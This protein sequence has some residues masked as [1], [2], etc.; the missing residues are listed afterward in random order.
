MKTLKIVLCLLLL[1]LTLSACSA[2]KTNDKWNTSEMAGIADPGFVVVSKNKTSN[3][4]K[5]LFKNVEV[6]AANEFLKQLYATEFKENVNYNYT[7]SFYTYAA[8]NSAGKSIDFEYNIAE[9]T[10]SFTYSLSGGTASVSGV[11][12]MGYFIGV[13]FEKDMDLDFKNYSVWLYYSINPEVQKTSQSEKTVSCMLKDI[14]IKSASRLG[15]L[16]IS[17]DVFKEATIN[18]VSC[19]NQ[20]FIDPNFIVRQRGI[21]KFSTD[22]PNSQNQKTYFDAMSV[23]QADLNFVVTFTAEVVTDKGTYTKAY[24]IPVL[25]AGSD[26]SGM[27]KQV[28]DVDKRITDVSKGTLYTKK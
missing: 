25:P 23:S 16:S 28:Y 19:L 21:G 14:K 8:S 1:G 15:S 7:Q 2:P 6:T 20:G 24:E 17:D 13:H 9:K 26:I 18:E 11:L 27:T 3:E 5:Y 22:I 12:D 10:A 4:I